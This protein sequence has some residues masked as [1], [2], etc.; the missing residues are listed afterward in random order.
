MVVPSKEQGSGLT[1]PGAI[2]GFSTGRSLVAGVAGGLDA[3]CR[4]L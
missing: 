1:R 3:D 4:V 2:S